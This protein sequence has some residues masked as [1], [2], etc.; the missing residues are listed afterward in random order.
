MVCFLFLHFSCFAAAN[1]VKIKA[2]VSEDF[3]EG[4][5]TKYLRYIAKQLDMPISI[6]T[7]PF[8][9]RL[10]EVRNGHLDIIVG[11]QRTKDREDE[12][13]YIEPSYESLSYQFFSLKKNQEH[14]K[15]SD[16][17]NGK[18][19]GVN[20]HSVYFPAFMEKSKVDLVYVNSLEQSVRLLLKGRTDL[21]IHYEESTLPTLKKMGVDDII[22]KTPYQENYLNN[23][24]I[25]ISNKSHLTSRIKDLEALVQK[26]IKNGD[27]NRMRQSHYANNITQ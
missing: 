1:E 3:P 10:Q 17:L 15:K 25:A 24:Y 14:F 20:K 8:A 23:H 7:M 18:I 22:A 9:R 16:D 21:V 5:H 26:A 27:F 12:F 6:S 13:I 2:A 4:L 11:L 19:V